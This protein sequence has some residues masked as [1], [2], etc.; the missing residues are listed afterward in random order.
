MNR[1]RDEFRRSRRR[2]PNAMLDSDAV[3][4]QDPSPLDEAIGAELMAD[5]E[6]ALGRS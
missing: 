5:Y 2:E 3:A 6:R 1:I 4:G